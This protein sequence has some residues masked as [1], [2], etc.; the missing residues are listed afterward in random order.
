M[1]RFKN[2]FSTHCDKL[3][4]TKC[5][6]ESFKTYGKSRKSIKSKATCFPCFFT[7]LHQACTSQGSHPGPP[8]SPHTSLPSADPHSSFTNTRIPCATVWPPSA[9][10]FV[11][12]RGKAQQKLCPSSMERE[13]GVSNGRRMQHGMMVHL[14]D[15][16]GHLPLQHSWAAPG[17]QSAAAR[18]RAVGPS[19]LQPVK[20]RKCYGSSGCVGWGRAGEVREER[21]KRSSL[22]GVHRN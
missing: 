4:T 3:K 15:H 11:M 13:P 21:Q 17:R 1:G 6:E 5:K 18:A 12:L 9:E 8:Q 14:R 19:R 22:K 7:E 10:C 20:R 16:G 2:K